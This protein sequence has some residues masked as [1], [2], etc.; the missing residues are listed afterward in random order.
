MASAVLYGSFGS[1]GGGWRAVFTEQNLHPRVHVSPISYMQTQSEN[2]QL[3]ICFN[4]W[5][6]QSLFLLIAA[7]CFNNL[8]WMRDAHHDGGC[9]CGVLSPSPTFPDV[10]TPG[11]LAH[12]KKHR[13]VSTVICSWKS[14]IFDVWVKLT[15]CQFVASRS[16][17]SERDSVW[18]L[19]RSPCA[20]SG[21]SVCSSAGCSFFQWGSPSSAT[22]EA[23]V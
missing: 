3:Q 20:G 23:S 8:K 10:W 12:L 2:P 11:L 13:N 22:E 9:S 19:W 15:K 4:I 16:F 14:W 17:S 21:L 6:H 18:V 1:R 5:R 7:L